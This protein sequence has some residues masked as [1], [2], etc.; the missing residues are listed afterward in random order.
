MAH[1]GEECALGSCRGLGLLFRFSQRL[2][3]FFL[4]GNVDVDTD[5]LPSAGASVAECLSLA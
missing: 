5:F 2:L 4:T 3:C 1:I